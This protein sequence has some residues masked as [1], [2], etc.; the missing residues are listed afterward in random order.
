[1]LY[2]RLINILPTNLLSK[3]VCATSALALASASIAVP[4]RAVQPD[5]LRL[6]LPV[7]GNLRVENFRGGVSVRVWNQNY[8]SV[9]ATAEDGQSSTALPVVD[10]GETLLSV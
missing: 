5:G 9:S 8:V 1:M 7:N 10:R 3:F 2:R 6:E 4:T